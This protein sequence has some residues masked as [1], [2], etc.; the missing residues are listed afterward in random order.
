MQAV[1]CR[2]F[3]VDEGGKAVGVG[4]GETKFTNVG[5]EGP[6]PL[7]K[8]FGLGVGGRRWAHRAP[9]RCSPRRPL[10]MSAPCL[11]LPKYLKISPISWV[12]RQKR[13]TVAS[14]PF[15]AP[16]QGHRP[17]NLL[18]LQTNDSI[19]AR[20]LTSADPAEKHHTICLPAILDSQLTASC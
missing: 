13:P 4:N 18:R 19:G 12:I 20:P 14:T 3:V 7:F 11:P 10:Q 15:P 5:W 6:A 16:L 1:D 2:S 17:L 8:G 9:I